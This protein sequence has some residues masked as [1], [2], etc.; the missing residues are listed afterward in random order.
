LVFT[1]VRFAEQKEEYAKR[2]EGCDS[3][4]E[5]FAAFHRLIGKIGDRVGW[6]EWAQGQ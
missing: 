4:N 1:L 3:E 6:F 5:V 2:G